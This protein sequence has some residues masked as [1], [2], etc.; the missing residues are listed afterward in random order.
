M[1]SAK[2]KTAPDDYPGGTG[3]AP[4]LEESVQPSSGE[5]ETE[6]CSD[7]SEYPHIVRGGAREGDRRIENGK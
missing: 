6:G 3:R 7:G 2:E 1:N 5:K 4:A